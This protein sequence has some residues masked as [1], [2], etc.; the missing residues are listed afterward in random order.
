MTWVGCAE[1]LRDCAESGYPIADVD[2]GLHRVKTGLPSRD[3]AP[4]VRMAVE[5]L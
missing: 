2:D 5:R 3:A 4:I 1:A